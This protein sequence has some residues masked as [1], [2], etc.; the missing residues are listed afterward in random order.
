MRSKEDLLKLLGDFKEQFSQDFNVPYKADA[1][2]LAMQ[3]ERERRFAKFLYRRIG[4]LRDHDFAAFYELFLLDP[5]AAAAIPEVPIVT[6][7]PA[8]APT[9]H[10]PPKPKAK[11]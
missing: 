3:E 6:L 5:P 1:L 2:K 8:E 4:H 9:V 11:K 7:P 10:I